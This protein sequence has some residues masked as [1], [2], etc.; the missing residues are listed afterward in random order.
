LSTILGSV[1]IL[2]N[3]IVAAIL[4]I[5]LFLIGQF[6]EKRYGQKF[7]YQW[8]LLPV[9]LFLIGAVWD[10]FVNDITGEP[11]LDFVGAY[12]SDLLFLLGGL[13]LIG[14]GYRLYRMMMGGRR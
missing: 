1:L 7:G 2:Y 13:I 9:A 12:G 14:L 10:V 8:L 5:F 3:W 6:Y 11:L 4:I